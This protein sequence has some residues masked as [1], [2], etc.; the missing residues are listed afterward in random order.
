MR[1]R[2]APEP[3]APPMPPTDGTSGQDPDACEAMLAASFEERVT[4]P[5]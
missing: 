4:G 1:A 3:R 5:G 2:R